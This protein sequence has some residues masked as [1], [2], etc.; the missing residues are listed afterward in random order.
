MDEEMEGVYAA[1]FRRYRL[2][3]NKP[4]RVYKPRIVDGKVMM[5]ADLRRLHKYML[6]IEHIHHISDEMRALVE[7]EW[8]ELAPRPAGAGNLA[9]GTCHLHQGGTAQMIATNRWGVHAR[10][11]VEAQRLDPRRQAEAVE[12]RAGFAGR[13]SHHVVDQ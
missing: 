8:P 1:R 5:P 7:S 13:A 12:T 6:G 3:G 11:L 2:S 4:H 10:L 9:A